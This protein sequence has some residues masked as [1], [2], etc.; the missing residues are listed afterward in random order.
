MTPGRRILFV[1]NP[2]AGRSEIRG[3]LLEVLQIFAAAG[4][5]SEVRP[6]APVGGFPG[7]VQRR[8]GGY[9]IVVPCGG[10][11]TLNETINGLMRLPQRPPLGYLP[12]GTVN[13]FAASLGIS[14]D[15]AE[16]AQCIVNGRSCPVDVGCFNDRFFSYIAA[17]GAFTEVSY[18]TPQQN[19]LILGRAAYILEGIKRLP[20]LK[21]YDM[22]VEGDSFSE[23]GEF[24]FGMVSNSSSVGGFRLGEKQ[25]ISMSDGLLEVTLVRNPRNVGELTATVNSILRQSFDSEFVHSFKTTGV[26]FFPQAAVPWTLDGEFGGTPVDVCISAARQALR[27][28]CSTPSETQ[29]SSG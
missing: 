10:D 29:A 6:S 5:T 1:I 2:H 18:Q 28:F 22:R 24:L 21:P 3:R 11:G 8:P 20:V 14:R 25:R 17:F 16:A 23:E 26:R 4:F 27:V 19:K 12:S 15:M 13:D 9:G 7:A